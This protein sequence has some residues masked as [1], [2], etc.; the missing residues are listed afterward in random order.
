MM[1]KMGFKMLIE[2]K[3]L[4]VSGASG[5]GKSY[6]IENRL[7]KKALEKEKRI[8]IFDPDSAF[9]LPDFKVISRIDD[10]IEHLKN[11]NEF[12]IFYQ[13][14]RYGDLEKECHNLAVIVDMIQEEYKQ[15]NGRAGYPIHFII[16]EA[17]NVFS[18]TM[19]NERKNYGLST[20]FRQGRKR[21][22]FLYLISQGVKDLNNAAKKN[23]DC[24]LVFR[25]SAFADEETVQNWIGKEG[26]RRFN[27][28]PEFSH[29]RIK[30]GK[31]DI[32]D[33]NFNEI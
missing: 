13:P 24:F 14:F 5:S 18:N 22:I 27:E 20:L 2:G 10:L 1:L 32:I 12:K 23:F 19:R 26:I 6:F 3:R 4:I 16:D 7:I 29:I 30:G 15:T 28:A 31:Y 11:N 8:I 21:G 25:F 33:N 17:H 9:D